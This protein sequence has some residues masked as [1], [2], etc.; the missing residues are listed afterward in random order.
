MQ[1]QA[2]LDHESNPHFQSPSS[3]LSCSAPDRK[4]DP[5]SRS[6]RYRQ[7]HAGAGLRPAGP[8]HAPAHPAAP[9]SCSCA[10]GALAGGPP[11]Q[12][13]WGCFVACTT[14][15]HC[16][17]EVPALPGFKISPAAARRADSLGSRAP[18]RAAPPR[19][20]RCRH[21]RSPP[22][23]ARPDGG[24]TRDGFATTAER[25]RRPW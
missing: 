20:A 18:G 11:Y 16:M 6:L 17:P 4:L 19:P 14:C 21:T 22:P 2:V 5:S 23:P 25:P 13:A 15:M 8:P 1:G 7:D 24:A 9:D 10:P 3:T 12:V